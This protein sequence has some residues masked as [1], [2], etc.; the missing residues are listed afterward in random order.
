MAPIATDG[1]GVAWRG[2]SV[3]LCVCQLGLR[4]YHVLD[5]GPDPLMERGNFE[6]GK[7]RSTVK[8]RVDS[9]L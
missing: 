8:Y 2:L 1:N 6:G 3:C 4:P 9:K 5:G 7:W